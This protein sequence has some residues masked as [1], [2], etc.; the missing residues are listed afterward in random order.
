MIL[1]NK[2][3]P[4][5]FTVFTASENDQISIS[6]SGLPHDSFSNYFMKGMQGHADAKRDGKI[7]L[8]EMQTPLVVNV[9]RHAGMMHGLK[10]PQLE[11]VF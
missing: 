6:K 4:E 1:L 7:T 3:F 8:S 2:L 5:T 9:A 11:P 10:A